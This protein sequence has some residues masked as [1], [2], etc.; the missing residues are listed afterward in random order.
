MAAVAVENTT[1]AG[2]LDVPPSTGFS[3]TS[4]V[5]DGANFTTTGYPLFQLGSVIV[6]TRNGARLA[7]ASPSQNVSVT[8][9]F[10]ADSG[11]AAVWFANSNGGSVTG[12][13][14]LH[15]NINPAVESTQ[16]PFGSTQLPLVLQAVQNVPAGTNTVDQTSGRVWVTDGQYRE[17]AAYAPGGTARLNAYEIGTLSS[18]SVVLADADGNVTSLTI[19]G[20]TAHSIDVQIPASAALGGAYLT[21]TSG[22]LKYF[23]TLFLDSQDNVPALNGCTYELSPSS[24]ATGAD[25]GTLPILVVTQAG[26]AY[27]VSVSDTFVSGSGSGSGTGVVAVGFAANASTTA[28][29]TTVEIVGQTVSLTQTA[30][31]AV[32]ARPVVQAIVD[33]WDYNPGLAPGEW[34]AIT[35]TALATGPARIWNLNGTQKTPITLGDVT[36]SFNGIAATLLYVSPTQINALVPAAV[37]PGPVQVVVQSNGVNG[38]PFVITATATQPAIYALPSSDGSTFFVTSALAGTA[39]LVG[40]NT[41]DPRVVRAAQPGDVLDLYMVGLGPTTDPSKFVT[42]QLFAGA[43]PVSASVTATV[44]GE[45]APV[46][47]AGLT[48]LGLYLVRIT[49]PSD[50]LPGPRPIRVSAGT[51]A[52]ASSLVLLLQASP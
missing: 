33:P 1:Q 15:P 39:T 6:N 46:A 4:N 20:S 10:I 22:S 18:P 43:F 9:N 32:S 16:T 27:S 13:I 30:A 17:L 21:L 38:V 31:S 34:V 19:Q 51:T 3:V 48:S 8:G 37:A 11:S 44:G 7:T 41:V 25:A 42:D 45:P 40:N 26:C 36:V 5:I 29:T 14:F 50:L 47:F 23:G 35:G 2:N 24:S 28:R 52:T 12:N 49:V